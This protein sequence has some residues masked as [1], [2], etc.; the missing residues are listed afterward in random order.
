MTDHIA[1]KY[2]R[3]QRKTP[4]VVLLC[5]ALAHTF[6]HT[7]L[8]YTQT[9]ALTHTQ[10]LPSTEYKLCTQHRP[11]T[12]KYLCTHMHTHHRS[13]VKFT[14]WML[15]NCELISN[16]SDLWHL[17]PTYE[18]LFSTLCSSLV[19]ERQRYFHKILCQ[20][21]ISLWRSS[22]RKLPQVSWRMLFAAFKSKF[23]KNML[24]MLEEPFSSIHDED[25]KSSLAELC[26]TFE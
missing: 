5:L 23:G 12:H 22:A 10:T 16:L 19:Q 6:T 8:H 2:N 17:H 4:N 26:L 25:S 1:R 3:V 11:K 18:P 9:Q 24:K 14:F 20:G 21:E 15:R 13:F 7:W